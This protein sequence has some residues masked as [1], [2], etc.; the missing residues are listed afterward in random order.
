MWGRRLALRETGKCLTCMGGEFVVLAQ[1]HA[2][3]VGAAGGRKSLVGHMC[4]CTKCGDVWC[5]SEGGVYKVDGR[6]S[7]KGVVQSPAPVERGK[8]DGRVQ[9]VTIPEEFR[10]R[11]SRV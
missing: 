1:V 7:G 3:G 11:K 6:L 2:V 4:A 9:E 8:R 5:V 10:E